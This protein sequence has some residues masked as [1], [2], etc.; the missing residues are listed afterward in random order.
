MELT[1]QNVSFSYGKTPTLDRIDLEVREGDILSIVGPNGSGKTT[2]I[3]CMNRKLTPQ[4]GTVM[5]GDTPLPTMKRKEIAKNIGVVPQVSSLSFP[6]SVYDLVMMGRYA[7]KG[8]FENDTAHDQAV[9]SECIA[10]TGLEQMADRS[11]TELSG[12]EYQK[13]IIARALAQEPAILLLDEVNL[14][15][16]IHHQIEIL[17]LIRQLCLERKMSVVMV[18][19]D[20]SLA[21]RYCTR[22]IMLK[23]GR[24]FASGDPEAVITTDNLREVYRIE[25]EISRSRNGQYLNIFPLSSIAVP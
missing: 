25:A 18:L 9:V 10:R 15:L 16:D 4:A 20:L 1:I 12:G 2:L 19:H 11:V 3:K 14:H 17:D 7:H 5:I 8:R 23:N 13:V 21:A 24:I 22:I 6:F